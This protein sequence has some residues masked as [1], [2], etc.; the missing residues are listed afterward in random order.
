MLLCSDKESDSTLTCS[1][2]H[3]LPSPAHTCLTLALTLAL[4]CSHSAHTLPYLACTCSRSAHTCSR[5]AHTLLTLCSHS[6]LT[7]PHLLTCLHLLSFCSLSALVL[8]TLALVLLTLCSHS[9]LTCPHLLTCLHLLSFC[10]LSALTRSPFF[11]SHPACNCS[12]TPAGSS[13]SPSSS[14]GRTVKLPRN[15]GFVLGVCFG[16]WGCGGEGAIMC[17]QREVRGRAVCASVDAYGITKRWWLC[18]GLMGVMVGV[19]VY[20]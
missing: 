1:H 5:S 16:V 4:S 15:G 17:V 14:S 20:S 6:A 18:I 7:C 13:T 11:C 9:A 19:G 10:S 12:L 8:L 3:T 2:L